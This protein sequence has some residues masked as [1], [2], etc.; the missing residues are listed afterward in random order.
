MS[1]GT[2]KKQKPAEN[3][4]ELVSTL[5][6]WQE[7]ESDSDNDDLRFYLTPGTHTLQIAEREK[8]TLIDAIVISR[9]D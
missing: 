4:A 1:E 7:I 6:R 8:E 3:T 9:V 2:E 5:R